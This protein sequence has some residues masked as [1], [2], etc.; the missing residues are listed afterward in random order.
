MPNS[1]KA[2]E[3]RTQ[4]AELR[5]NLTDLI[6]EVD[7][8]IFHKSKALEKEYMEHV[9]QLELQSFSVQY[10]IL[11]TK[12]K[13]ELVEDLIENNRVLDLEFIDKVIDVD[14]EEYE[15]LLKEQTNLL[16]LSLSYA[17]KSRKNEDEGLS[18]DYRQL[19]SLLHPDLN[20]GLDEEAG[21]LFREGVS[22]Y[23]K[24]D[25]QTLRAALD[26]AASY[27]EGSPV[28]ADALKETRNLLS[29]ALEDLREQQSLLDKSF[30]FS[31]A[32]LL[33]DADQLAAK[34]CELQGH[35]AYYESHLARYEAQLKELLLR[36]LN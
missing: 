1:A 15:N 35:I 20:A 8:T 32:H 4:I 24:K 14:F 30:P 25:R 3:L 31:S 23:A 5:K 11:R 36:K 16:K 18:A 9:G 2:E 10:K 17:D 21:L 27:A 12:R 33:E 29:K 26:K 13:L 28:P 34:R 22:A 7:C 6:I 19:V